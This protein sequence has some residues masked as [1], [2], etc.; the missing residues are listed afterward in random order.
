MFIIKDSKTRYYI[1]RGTEQGLNI[2][3]LQARMAGK[4]ITI[5]YPHH[6]TPLDPNNKIKHLSK[7]YF[8]DEVIFSEVEGL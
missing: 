1:N 7:L 4:E 8:E 3:D 6:W 5:K 2:E